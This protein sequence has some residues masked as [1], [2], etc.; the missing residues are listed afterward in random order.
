LNLE[1]LNTL[2]QLIAA[3]GVIG[4]LFYLG[5]QIRQNTRSMRAVVVDSL[6]K[7]MADIARPLAEQASLAE[8]F[9]IVVEDWHRAT[10]DQRRRVLFMLF[11]TFKQYENA[12]F[13]NQEGSLTPAQWTGW[14]ALIRM[15]YHGPG[16]KTWWPMRRPH[17]AEGFRRYIETSEPIAGI[18][19]ISEMIHGKAN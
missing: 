9:S 17:F 18:T 6:A 11:A 5:A 4:S 12:W 15:Y 14:D 3:I 13:Q 2:A 7:S 10:D 16:V 19:P 8:A 1:T